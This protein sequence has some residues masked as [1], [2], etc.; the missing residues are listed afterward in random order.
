MLNKQ[1]NIGQRNA[2]FFDSRILVVDDAALNRELILSYLESAGFKNLDVAVDGKEALTKIE[3]F[4]PDIM[5]LDLV[6]PEMDGVQVIKALRKDMNLKHLPIIV[7]TALSEPEQRIEA[8]ESGASDVITKP[9][10]RLELLS[11]VKVQLENSI[12]LQELEEYQKVAQKDIDQAFEVQQS[13]L[14]SPELVAELEQ[15]HNIKIDSL[16]VPSRFLSGDMWGILDIGPTQL[17]IWIC[18][19]SGKGIRAALHTFRLHTLIQ[20]FKH[21]ADDPGE[22]IDALNSR[23]ISVMPAGQFSTF[24]IGV[25]DFKTDLFTYTS[26]SAT[27]PLIYFPQ[28]KKFEV[29]DGSGV[30]LGIVAR[31]S[32]P[33]RTMAFSKGASLILYSDLLWEFKAVPGVFLDEGNLDSFAKELDGERVVQTVRDQVGLL[34]DPSFSDD[35]TLIEV[36][37]IPEEKLER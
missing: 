16:F 17:V 32:Y 26:A 27:H 24:L 6:M 12:L 4:F 5:I 37:R 10:H 28:E 31:P 18:D 7:Q 35:L 34:G 29:G 3:T 13:L 15:R 36:T 14:P 19:F 2:A 11:R 30:P 9:I 20:E 8:W 23:L 21:C 22:I 25:I 33:L 1:L